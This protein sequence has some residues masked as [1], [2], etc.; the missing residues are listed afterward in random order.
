MARPTTPADLD[1][2]NQMVAGIT[3]LLGMLGARWRDEAAYENID[4]YAEVIRK[5]LPSGFTLTRMTKRP[6]GFR[7]TIGAD[8][9]YALSCGA[10]SIA[11][12]RIKEA[13]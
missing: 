7:F 4:D 13:K 11:W 3:K 6:F 1:R 12:K 5:A 8:A 2:I 9:T 10:S